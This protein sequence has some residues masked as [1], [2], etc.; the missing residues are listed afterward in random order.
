MILQSPPRNRKYPH[1]NE[2]VQFSGFQPN[3]T[4]LVKVEE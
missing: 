1:H 4:L 3:K 2:S